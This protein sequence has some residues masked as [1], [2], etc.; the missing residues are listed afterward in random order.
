MSDVIFKIYPN[1][2]IDNGGLRVQAP[3]GAGISAVTGTDS[4]NYEID[5]YSTSLPATGTV[6]NKYD[7]RF[8]GCP[9]CLSIG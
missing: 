7:T 9:P 1:E 6:F 2:L 5:T 8:T 4:L 3:K